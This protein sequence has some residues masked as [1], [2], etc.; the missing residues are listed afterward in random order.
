MEH[1]YSHPTLHPNCPDPYRPSLLGCRLFGEIDKAVPR[2]MRHGMFCPIKRM[3]RR[4]ITSLYKHN[5]SSSGFM[6]VYI[7]TL[8]S[9]EG[10]SLRALPVE[11]VGMIR[12]SNSELQL[13]PEP[14]NKL[15][16]ASLKT[17]VVSNGTQWRRL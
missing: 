9:W 5:N 15:Y 16:H 14:N 1:A 4:M 3:S 2:G 17:L 11:M 6:E 12:W 7:P 10:Y 13:P 8:A